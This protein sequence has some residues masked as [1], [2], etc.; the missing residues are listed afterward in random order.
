[1]KRTSRHPEACFRHAITGALVRFD[2]NQDAEMVNWASQVVSGV[3]T[4][5][6]RRMIESYRQ[7]AQNRHRLQRRALGEEGVQPE[8]M[9]V[10]R[11]LWGPGE[12]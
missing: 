2:D 5:I 4:P 1:M 10:F 7:S 6:T 11:D 3:S 8:T 9:V 12:R